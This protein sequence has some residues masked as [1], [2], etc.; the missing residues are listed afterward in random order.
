MARLLLVDAS[1]P[2]RAAAA[3][4]LRG[5]GHAVASV[6]DAAAATAVLLLAPADLLVLDAAAADA[7]ADAS[8]GGR[9]AWMGAAPVVLIT[10][11]GEDDDARDATAGAAGLDVRGRV[12]RADFTPAGLL[13]VVDAALRPAWDEGRGDSTRRRTPP[14]DDDG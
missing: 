8:A 1:A 2:F 12:W 13:A 4:A 10:D 3:A 6:A 14:R 7:V 9:C 5:R 11:G